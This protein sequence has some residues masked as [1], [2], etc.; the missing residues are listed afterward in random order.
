MRAAH[1]MSLR[2]VAGRCP[3]ACGF[4][5]YTKSMISSI[6]RSRKLAGSGTRYDDLA[7]AS[8]SMPRTICAVHSQAFRPTAKISGSSC[9][10]CP[11]FRSGFGDSLWWVYARHPGS[12]HAH[13]DA[14]A[15][16]GVFRFD[17]QPSSSRRASKPD[18]ARHI[19]CGESMAVR[20]GQGLDWECLGCSSVRL[21]RRSLTD[22]IRRRTRCR[23]GRAARS[24]RPRP[25]RCR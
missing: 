21:F 19:A 7:F 8:G 16:A 12:A 22:R 15:G 6:F 20:V 14:R 17:Q 4:P 2:R 23:R 10:R 9:S 3:A 24:G 5:S 18:V 25:G 1:S 13:R 11:T